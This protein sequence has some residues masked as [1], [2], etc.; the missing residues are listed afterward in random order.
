MP[1]TMSVAKLRKATNRPSVL[2]TGESE[3]PVVLVVPLWFWL[4]RVRVPV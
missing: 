4:T 1:G 3:L 2:T